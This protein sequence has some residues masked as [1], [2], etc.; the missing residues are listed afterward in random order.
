ME[1]INTN[2]IITLIVKKNFASLYA[3][4]RILFDC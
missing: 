2:G 3:S 1:I 4:F